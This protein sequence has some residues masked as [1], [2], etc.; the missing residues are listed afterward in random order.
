LWKRSHTPLTSTVG[1]HGR[2]A[3]GISQETV[4]PPPETGPANT[5][6][7]TFTASQTIEMKVFMS[8]SAHGAVYQQLELRCNTK[9]HDKHH[10][11][12]P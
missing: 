7:L 1:R 6:D 8:H 12:K 10:S 4:P 5:S 2:K 11:L 9:L 3:S